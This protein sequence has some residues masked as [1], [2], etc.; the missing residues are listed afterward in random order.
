MHRSLLPATDERGSALLTVMAVAVFVSLTIAGVVMLTQNRQKETQVDDLRLSRDSIY[1]QVVAQATLTSALRYSMG[2]SDNTSFR[3]CMNNPA[4]CS[5]KTAASRG[6]FTLYFPYSS[7]SR[8]KV[9][10]GSAPAFY[11]S[12]GRLMPAGCAASPT[13]PFESRVYF[14][15]KQSTPPGG[16]FDTVTVQPE[17]HVRAGVTL[18][19]K[20]KLDP[21]PLAKEIATDATLTKPPYLSKYEMKIIDVLRAETSCLPNSYLVNAQ[22]LSGTTTARCRCVPGFAPDDPNK[23]RPTCTNSVCP[24]KKVFMGFNINGLAECVDPDPIDYVCTNYSVPPNGVVGCPAGTKMRAAQ[25]AKGNKCVLQPMAGCPKK[26]CV[27]CQNMT[28]T[29][30]KLK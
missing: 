9:A 4:G 20:V 12:R 29:C 13:C 3:N 1:R 11:T 6:S 23:D 15:V 17:V 26:E 10:S 16:P 22:N 8:P 28:I 2:Q 5:A 19:L 18:P 30:C 7:T 21:R 25:M 14:W 24:P 27:K